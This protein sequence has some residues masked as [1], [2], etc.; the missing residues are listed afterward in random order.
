MNSVSTAVKNTAAD[1]FF[2]PDP[3]IRSIASELYRDAAD[4]PIVCPH[5]HVDPYLF[6]DANVTFGSPAHLFIIPDHYVFRMHYSQ[7]MALVISSSGSGTTS[8]PG[9]GCWYS[10]QV[11]PECFP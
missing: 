3:A 5:G 8:S 6:A 1:R 4:L 7:G 9:R 10:A 2:D 11:A